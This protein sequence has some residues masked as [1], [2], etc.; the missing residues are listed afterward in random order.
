M[1]DSLEDPFARDDKDGW[2][3]LAD[4]DIQVVSDALTAMIREKITDAFNMKLAN[5][6]MLRI[7]QIGTVTEL[8]DYATEARL[9]NWGC[10]IGGSP[11][12]TEESFIADLA[13]GLS[14]GQFKA[15]APCRSER[16]AKYNRLLQI[17]EELGKDAKY[18][19]SNYRNL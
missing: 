15:G 19:G 16:V 6:L 1:I 8:I 7:S 18:V 10:I 13:V 17:E 2:L 5:T 9:H 12:E 14:V 3:T 11:C 4:Q